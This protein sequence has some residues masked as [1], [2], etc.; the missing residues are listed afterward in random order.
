[1]KYVLTKRPKNPTIVL[2]FPTIGLVSTIAT[3]F[4]IDHLNVEVI[5]YLESEKIIPLTAIHKSKIVEPITLYYNRNH[6]LI[7]VQ[8]LTEING[9]EWDTAETILEMA[10]DLASKEILVLESAPTSEGKL[11][12]FYF[13]TG[14]KKT[15]NIEKLKEGIVMG[16][17]AALLLKGQEFPITCFFAETQHDYPDSEAAARLVDALNKYLG[18][19]VDSKP[20]LKAAKEFEI[21]LKKYMEKAKD[22]NP[23]NK[24]LGYIG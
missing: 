22:M 7:I 24:D 12:I 11:D 8:S 6:N 19:K 14:D 20:L 16:M 21:N 18:M 13:S 23:S 15:M 10:E 5:G 9:L 1:M 17:T 2:G 4:L 3:K